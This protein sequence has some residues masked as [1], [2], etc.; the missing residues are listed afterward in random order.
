M[1]FTGVS[2]LFRN[3][4]HN[5]SCDIFYYLL[6]KSNFRVSFFIWSNQ[7]LSNQNVN[8][9]FPLGIDKKGQKV[10]GLYFQLIMK[11]SSSVSH[12]FILTSFG[13]KITDHMLKKFNQRHSINHL[14]CPKYDNCSEYYKIIRKAIRS[15]VLN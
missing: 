4:A 12:C 8:W 3:V 1:G 7:S 10:G 5:L 15:Q 13:L 9:T 6:L 2:G 11:I 14:F